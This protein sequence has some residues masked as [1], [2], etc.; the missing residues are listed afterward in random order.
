M[1]SAAL[2]SLAAY[3]MMEIKVFGFQVTSKCDLYCHRLLRIFIFVQSRISTVCG[4]FWDFIVNRN[5][6]HSSKFELCSK[7][8]LLFDP[9]LLFINTNF[10]FLAFLL[11]LNCQISDSSML[12]TDPKRS[13]IFTFSK[14]PTVVRSL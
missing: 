10:T 1:F 5:H 11:N 12:F 8:L 6:A 14:V 2:F 9:H 7:I 13:T 4:T 3:S